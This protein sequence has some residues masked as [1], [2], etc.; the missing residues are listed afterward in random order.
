M[1]FLIWIQN[2]HIMGTERHKQ[3]QPAGTEKHKQ[4][5]KGTNT[6]NAH[7]RVITGHLKFIPSL[8][9]FCAFFHPMM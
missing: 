6:K 8:C 5:Q 1:E 4:A 3:A 9:L 7:Y 2:E